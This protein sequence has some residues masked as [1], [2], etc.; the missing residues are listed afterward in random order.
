MLNLAQPETALSFPVP[1]LTEGQ[2]W[3]VNFNAKASWN[4]CLK[5]DL[6]I[7]DALDGWHVSG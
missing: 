2:A 4:P 7:D 6:V 5:L 1:C 3:Q